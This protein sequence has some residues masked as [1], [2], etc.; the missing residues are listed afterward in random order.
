[1]T[2]FADTFVIQDSTLEAM[3]TIL[4]QTDIDNKSLIIKA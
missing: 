4:P 3:L 1:M 2:A